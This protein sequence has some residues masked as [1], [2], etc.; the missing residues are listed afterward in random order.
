MVTFVHPVPLELHQYRN[1]SAVVARGSVFRMVVEGN[2][3]F[4]C[5]QFEY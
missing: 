4:D 1:H 3:C 2:T 5:L